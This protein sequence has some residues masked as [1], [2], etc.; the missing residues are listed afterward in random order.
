MD[1]HDDCHRDLR[2]V[3]DGEHR[4]LPPDPFLSATT[5]RLA[6]ARAR[7]TLARRCLLAAALAAVTLGSPW[8]ISGS[9][10]L[11]AR[12]GTL[13][14]AVAGWLSTPAG[15]VAA[16]LLLLAALVYRRFWQRRSLF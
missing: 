6:K 1:T 7:A 3:F 15:T 16:L 12:L 11:S 13:F 2:D 14:G 5:A 8:L 9:V 4:Q 10:L